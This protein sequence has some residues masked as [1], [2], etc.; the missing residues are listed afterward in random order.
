MR[1]RCPV[2]GPQGGSR[3]FS[4]QGARHP[5]RLRNSTSFRGS[6]PSSPT[7][8]IYEDSP[9]TWHMY[10]HSVL[11]IL[12]DVT[13]SVTTWHMYEDSPPVRP[14]DSPRPPVRQDVLSTGQGTPLSDRK[15]DTNRPGS[16][17]VLL[18][19]SWPHTCECRHKVISTGREFPGTETRTTS[20]WRQI[21]EPL[22]ETVEY[23]GTLILRGTSILG[24]PGCHSHS[25]GGLG[26]EWGRGSRKTSVLDRHPKSVAKI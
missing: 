21:R 16:L 19:S 26:S 24:S 9:P 11:G 17:R 10:E 20:R 5:L 3:R 18:S 14:R 8:H 6:D 25:S 12:P 15:R 2:S 22:R 13:L 1:T 4:T 23:V 7:S